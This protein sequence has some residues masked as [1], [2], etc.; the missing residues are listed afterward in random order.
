MAA[1]SNYRPISLLQIGFK[2]FAIVLLSRLKAAGAESRI[3]PT[4]FEFRSQ[5][6]TA[7]ALFVARRLLD[8]AWAAADGK[9]VFLAL[10]WAK[11]FDCIEPQSLLTALHR[12]ALPAEFVEMVESIYEHRDFFVRGVGVPSDLHAQRAGICQ[13][14]PL[15]PFL[16]VN[17]CSHARR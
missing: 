10:D 3:W 1:C 11:A 9:L 2:I 16:F 5:H 13:G 12:F 6:G 14:C 7:D 8:D 4:Q 17:E 15:G